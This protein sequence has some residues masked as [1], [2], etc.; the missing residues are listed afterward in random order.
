M[1]IDPRGVADM[2][3]PERHEAF[4]NDRS[5][6][7]GAAPRS[8]HLPL[9]A[10]ETRAVPL[11]EGLVSKAASTQPWGRSPAAS[12]APEGTGLLH[13]ETAAPMTTIKA[14]VPRIPNGNGVMSCLSFRRG[15]WPR[16]RAARLLRA[17]QGSVA[18][19]AGTQPS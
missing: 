8:C 10:F 3:C 1:E 14:G 11:S 12:W 2:L 15:G 18:G 13:P 9:P 5:P 7:G 4:L 16:Y 6:A 17:P 19:S